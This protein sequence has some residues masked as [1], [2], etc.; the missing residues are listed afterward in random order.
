MDGLGYLIQHTI[1]QKA[2]QKLS[3]S[4]VRI[5][6]LL[7]KHWIIIASAVIIQF[8]HSLLL[9]LLNHY[10]KAIYDNYDIIIIL[11][12]QSFI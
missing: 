6:R 9:L 10:Y 12:S 1:P 11:H 8:I 5:I 3:D 4:P 2:R 7:H